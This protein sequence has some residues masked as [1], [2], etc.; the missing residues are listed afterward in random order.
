[1]LVKLPDQSVPSVRRMSVQLIHDVILHE[2]DSVFVFTEH[3][4]ALVWHDLL[5][6]YN[7]DV[8]QVFWALHIRQKPGA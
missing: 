2:R 7:Q 3:A 5:Q 8:G 1:M 6:A 4:G